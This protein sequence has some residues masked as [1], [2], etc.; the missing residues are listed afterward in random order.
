MIDSAIQTQLDAAYKNERTLADRIW[1]TQP[2]GRG[3]TRDL[4]WAEGMQEA[5]KMAAYLASLE[6]PKG[7]RISIF[8]KNCAWWILADL[9]IWM[10]GHVT[11]PI[12]PTLSPDSIRQILEHSDCK[13]IFIGKLD[14]YAAMGPG[15]P[16]AIAKIGL[17]LS[18]DPTARKWDEIIAATAPIA[19][20]P[21][22]EPDELATI[23]YTSGSTGVPKGVMHSFKSM[24]ATRVF[25]ES[26][27]TTVDD[28]M[29]S[30][31]PLAHVAERGLLEIPNLFVGY[32]VFFAESLETFLVDLQRA[33]PTVFGSVPRLWLKFQSGIFE[34]VPPNKLARLL[35]IPI[36]GRLVKRKILRGLGL[37]QVRL[38]VCGSAPVPTEML[39]W[40]AQL[41]LDIQ[42]LYGMTENMAISHMTRTADRRIGYVGST[43]AG[44]TH[45]I[46]DE[47]EVLVKSPGTMLGYY[48][49]EELTREMLDADGWIHTGDRG[50]LDERGR[51]KITGRVKELFKTSK[52]K[53]VAP[54]PIENALLAD[55]MIEQACVT[56]PGLGQPL[57]LI[58][59]SPIGK[60][61]A[62][63]ATTAA[64]GT[65]RE[66]VNRQR[67]PHEHLDRIVVIGDEWTVDNGLLT[68][69][70]K[71]RRS[72]IEDRYGK[73]LATWDR[74]TERVVWS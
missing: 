49:A 19:G 31:L 70:M 68:P 36:L 35:R 39:E 10:S 34:K 29:L 66:L 60:R 4:T 46:T 27:G 52:G 43:V 63:D 48:R 47:G 40:Y 25:I 74:A 26:F 45:K 72:A 59:L 12:Y 37:D 5:R 9:A 57:A 18:A 65:L 42:E 8:S 20:D 41:G 62:R 3:V 56:G 53:Y 7:T 28:R 33:R 44:V 71:L 64:L 16:D 17:P 23:I 50:E 54:A 55:P 6:L 61:E 51:L 32:R 67:D 15:I 14:G 11:V 38:A 13:L 22:R 73:N 1:L 21:H 24:C 30:Y 2:M 69:T 58:V